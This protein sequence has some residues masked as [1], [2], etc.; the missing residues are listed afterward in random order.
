MKLFHN[1]RFILVNTI[2]IT[3]DNNI[4][5][6]DDIKNDTTL[7]IYNIIKLNTSIIYIIMRILKNFIIILI[8]VF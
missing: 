6:N 2:L 4:N 1:F 7:N 3:V 5:N 8:N